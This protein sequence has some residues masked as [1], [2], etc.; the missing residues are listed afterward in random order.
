MAE[1]F[2]GEIRIVGFGFAP[3]GWALCNGQVL[4]IQQNTALFSLLG[5]QYGGDGVQT[6]A[7]PN[8]QSRVPVHQGQ[9]PGLTPYTIGEVTGAESVTLTQGQ[10]P[11]HQHS[12]APVSSDQAQDT[13]R[14][15][16]A[17]PTTGGIYASTQGGGAPMAPAVSSPTGGSQPHSNIQPLLV[18]NFV[19]ALEGIFPSR[20]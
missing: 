20:S 9:G 14:P 17:F 12:V 10:I 6:F 19:I 3:Q 11:A 15:G 1:P 2:L 8:L 7:L 4:S 5:T 16:G 18:V 13:N